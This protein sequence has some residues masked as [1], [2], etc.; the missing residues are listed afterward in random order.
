MTPVTRVFAESC[1]TSSIV[2]A[3]SSWY[4]IHPRMPTEGGALVDGGGLRL[5]QGHERDRAA[6]G[7]HAEGRAGVRRRG[8]EEQQEH[9]HSHRG[10]V[11]RAAAT[12]TGKVTSGADRA[13]S[14]AP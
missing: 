12:R 2:A 1:S 6:T 8:G 9:E 10:I 3:R 11:A 14:G 13:T 7:A 5:T 4:W